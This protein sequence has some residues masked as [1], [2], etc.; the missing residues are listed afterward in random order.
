MPF[1]HY[2]FSDDSKHKG[3]KRIQIAFNSTRGFNSHKPENFINFWL[4]DP[5]HEND[6]TPVK[7]KEYMPKTNPIV[8]NQKTFS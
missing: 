3:Y 8:N 6:K 2:A 5:Q 1:T 7:I 4:Y